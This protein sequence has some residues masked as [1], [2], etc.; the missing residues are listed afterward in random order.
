MKN[1]ILISAL[2]AYG[3]FGANAAE[4]VLPITKVTAFSSGV[5]YFEHQGRVP[6]EAEVLLKFRTEAINDMLKSL[7]VV[8]LGGGVVAGVNYAS[9]EPVEHALKTLGIDLSDGPSLGKLL[10]RLRGVEVVLG[11]PEK[12]SGKILGVEEKTRHLLPSDTIVKE[13][14]LHLV[15]SEGIKTF[16]LDTVRSITLA[17]DTLNADLNRALALLAEAHDTQSKMVRIRLSGQGERPVRIGYIAEA[18]VWKTTYRLVLDGAEP[19]KA[20]LHGWAIIENTSDFDWEGVDLTLVSGRPISFVEDLYTPLFLPRPQVRTERYVGLRPQVYEEGLKEPQFHALELPREAERRAY[21]MA[22][23]AAPAAGAGY[24]ARRVDREV[25]EKD[26]AQAMSTSL[27]SVATAEAVGEL[28]SYHVK[29]PVT[30]PRR[31]SAMLPILNQAVSARPVSIYNANVLA[32]HPLN[33]LWLTNDTGASLLG[34]PVTVIAG[35]TYAGDA[36]IGNLSPNDRRLLSYAIDLKVTVD[37]TSSQQQHAAVTK[38][39]RGVLTLTRK[40]TFTQ[41]YVIRNKA[42]QERTVVVEH[43]LQRGR[44]LVQPAEPTEKTP[45]VYRFEVSVAPEKTEKL[46]VREEQTALQA[47]ELLPMDVSA[48]QKT[49]AGAEIPEKA[50]QALA[51]AVR[52]KTALADAERQVKELQDRIASLR[53]SQSEVRSNMTALTRQSQGYQRFEAKLLE[54]ETQIEALEKELE[55]KRA[56][57]EQARKQLEDY[58]ARLEVEA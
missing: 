16:P 29:T 12:V 3:V 22:E 44:K 57:A 28:F 42:D 8:D 17:N 39:S 31:S 20:L 4:V 13:E 21:A 32:T 56:A 11:L 9:R 7:T 23:P 55:G 5:A 14:V 48:L 33:G 19:G 52:L 6:G 24:G 49:I 15:T 58:L 2:T 53:K 36:Q 30:L 45:N 51:E 40:T 54:M 1:T 10:A 47:V 50:R 25:E 35:G 41:T 34:G 18:P 46:E 26:A 37:P 27:R 38:I 43:P